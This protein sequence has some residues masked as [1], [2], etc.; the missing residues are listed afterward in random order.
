[1][2]PIVDNFERAIKLDDSNLNDDLSKFLEGFKMIYGSLVDT[3]K[4]YE[5]VEIDCLQKEFDPNTMEAV[6]T[7]LTNSSPSYL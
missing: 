6:M 5:I 7:L 2:L 3:L 4:L 1:M